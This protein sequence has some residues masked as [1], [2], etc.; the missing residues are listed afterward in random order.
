MLVLKGLV[1]LHRTVRLQLLKYYWLGHRLGLQVSK[2]IF[3]YT[4]ILALRIPC[5]A[6]VHRV[7]KNRTR[8]EQ[9]IMDKYIFIL[10]TILFMKI[11]LGILNFS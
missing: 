10:N 4:G 7:A 6:T 5:R 2:Y 8:L 3:K 1:G 11:L 9:L